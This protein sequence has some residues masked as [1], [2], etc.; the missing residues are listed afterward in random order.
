[1]GG[2]QEFIV[3]NYVSHFYAFKRNDRDNIVKRHRKKKAEDKQQNAIFG[4]HR[5]GMR[6]CCFYGPAKLSVFCCG[7]GR[8][9]GWG[10][11]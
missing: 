11:L 10:C 8:L 6:H 2:R 9:V 3:K 7:G 4:R 1:M 5:Q